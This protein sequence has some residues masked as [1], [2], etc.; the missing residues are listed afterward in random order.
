MAETAE[1]RLSEAVPLAHALVARLAE[2]QGVR[3][4]FI[5]GPTAV[6]LGARPPRVSTDVDVLCEPGGLER[7]GPAMEHSGWRRRLR[8]TAETR[9]VHASQYLF[10]HSIHYIHDEWPCDIDIHF[11]FPGFL[12]PDDV[13]F[14]ELWTRHTSLNVAHWPVPCADYLGQAAIVAL[15]ALRDPHLAHTAPDLQFVTQSLRGRGAPASHDLAALAAAT[16]SAETLRPVLEELEITAPQG[17]SP[18]HELLRRWRV[19]T[20]DGSVPTTLWMIEVRNAK[21][22]AKP[23][24]V[25][26]ALLPPTDALYSSHPDVPRSSRNTTRLLRK[27]WRRALPHLRR[28]VNAARRAEGR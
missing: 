11:N 2:L 5:K 22:S 8:K 1:L 20:G 12:A 13:V 21:W 18:D 9:F 10:D 24:L 6:A 27:R 14:E 4:L 28:G 19:R 7:L 15:H 17:P 23:R 16:G 25:L 26:R 3:I